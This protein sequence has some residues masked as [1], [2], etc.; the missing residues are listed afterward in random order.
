MRQKEMQYM[1]DKTKNNSDQHV[2][3]PYK[4]AV[5]MIMYIFF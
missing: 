5:C 1:Q 3:T 2:L 4:A